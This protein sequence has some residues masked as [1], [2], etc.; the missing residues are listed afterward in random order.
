[1]MA[2]KV[3]GCRVGP[4]PTRFIVFG[5]VV[6]GLFSVQAWG[7]Y[8]GGTGD[9]GD[10]F[11]IA[12]PNQLIYMSEHP[13][14][15]SQH[16]ILI[17]D[18][19]LALADP[20]TFTT[21]LIA[22]DTDN[23]TSG[24]QGTPFTGVFD[25]NS[26]VIRNLIID[27]QY[28]PTEYLGLFGQ[29]Y[30]SGE[31]KNLAMENVSFA[32]RDY[33]RY[34]G[35]I[36][37]INE[38]L[39]TH[40]NV[41]GQLQFRDTSGAIGGLCGL[42][43]STISD[44]FVTGTI[45]VEDGYD[46]VGGLCGFNLGTITHSY[47]TGSV[48]CGNESSHIGGLCGTNSDSYN[49]EGII[50]NCY[51]TGLIQAENDVRN[52]GGLCGWNYGGK[53]TSCYANG[54]VTAGI[55]S[56]NLGGLCGWSQS[57]GYYDSMITQCYAAGMV[58]GDNGSSNIGG[59]CGK[60]YSES[61]VTLCY[62][63]GDVQGGT[64]SFNLGG[65]CGLNY[66]TIDHC[67]ADGQIN[68]GDVLGGFCGRNGGAISHSY[69]IG[70]VNGGI[71]S[72][73]LGGLCGYNESSIVTCFWDMDTSGMN[74]SAGGKPRIT[75][76]MKTATN[77]LG[78]NDGSWIL[79]EG[80]DYPRLFWQG[81]TG[82]VITTD[83][84]P[85]SYS[86]DFTP[87]QL[88]S[89]EDLLSLSL[90][91]CDWD[92]SF[93]ITRDID[94]SG[95]ANYYPP[96]D[97]CGSLDGQEHV[98]RNLSLDA[99]L[100]GRKS[101][102]GLI[103]RMSDGSVS[104]LGVENCS[105]IGIADSDY[106]GGLV[107]HIRYGEVTNCYTTG[108]ING[109]DRAYYVGGLS[110]FNNSANIM[111]CFSLASV[112]SG[113]LSSYTGGLS[114]CHYGSIDNCYSL[115]TVT[116]DINV[117]GLVGQ[118][119][120][121]I[122][123]SSASGLVAGVTNV[124]GLVG[125][126]TYEVLYCYTTA[127]VFGQFNVGGL[128]GINAERSGG[129]YSCYSIGTITGGDYS[130]YLGG[131]C[132]RNDNYISSCYSHS[133]IS[134]GDYSHSLGGL[135]GSNDTSYSYVHSCFTTGMIAGGNGSYSIGGFFGSNNETYF[136]NCFWDKQTSGCNDGVGNMEPDPDGVLGYTTAQMRRQSTFTNWDFLNAWK[137][138]E[139][140]TYPYLRKFPVYDLKKDGIT[141][142]LDFSRLAECWLSDSCVS[143][144]VCFE[145]DINK[146]G[147]IFITDLDILFSHWLE[148]F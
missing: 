123:D 95:V 66:G 8:D 29:I 53:I 138:D 58:V 108:L 116:G 127:N 2:T 87:F 75:T 148:N 107:G 86:T 68:G 128:C 3:A 140:Q 110:G 35:G 70:T 111:N 147:R 112:T 62:A 76:Q 92:K 136:V 85:A 94:M 105:V 20:N 144:E 43:T 47:T 18:I 79:N 54:S 126:N 17:A 122:Y 132:G 115:G 16:F 143:G 59:L 82:S 64:D 69:A 142:M 45:T 46:S 73:D 74:L 63:I 9:P 5:F 72:V 15:W 99:A 90:R 120:G 135:C 19:N 44:C 7:Q 89:P 134:G 24:F 133:A 52:I 88:D 6:L 60:N 26:H 13:E 80:N 97:F 98:V 30:E 11:E 91:V 96:S 139:N 50:S 141:D 67:Y 125:Q 31:V 71:N 83:Y 28:I 77:Y 78:W 130:A 57:H 81:L 65:I 100:L 36:C 56:T 25:G 48:N 129:I 49:Y 22:P 118:T 109:G 21:A 146:D 84:P 12:E 42:N 55:N 23:S 113:Q 104:N 124:G 37:G 93:I 103:G 137:I 102:L 145:F 41:R 114:G 106:L 14:H 33:S 34:L 10:P 119:G 61:S 121:V 101:Q 27:R 1:M 39:V 117:G 32:C 38:G 51:A 40:C 131:L 4:G